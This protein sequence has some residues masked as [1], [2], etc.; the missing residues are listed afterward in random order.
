M[1]AMGV[2]QKEDR[3]GGGGWGRMIKQ[4]LNLWLGL[5]KDLLC[6][7]YTFSTKVHLLKINE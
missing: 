4:V 6:L 7:S 5:C 1:V 2:G 3:K